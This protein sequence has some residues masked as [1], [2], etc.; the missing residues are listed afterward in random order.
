VVPARVETKTPFFIFAKSENRRKFAHFSQNFVSR[1]FSLSR[2]IFVPWMVVA[3]IL[4]NIYQGSDL[5]THSSGSWIRIRI[6]NGK[7]LRKLSRN[8]KFAAKIL[9]TF[10]SYFAKSEKKIVAQFSRNY[11]NENF[12]FN[13]SA[14]H[15]G[16]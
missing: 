8:R 16:C 4:D 2:K 5:A 6:P 10:R 12:R 9:T 3:K 13:P 11:E 14:G 7:F 15:V 1:K